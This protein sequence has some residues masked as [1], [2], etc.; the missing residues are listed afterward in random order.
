MKILYSMDYINVVYRRRGVEMVLYSVLFY[1]RRW[2]ENK[3][4]LLKYFATKAD[5]TIVLIAN[6]FTSLQAV[7]SL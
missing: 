5:W 1:C 4:I 2:G 3:P 7:E 6:F